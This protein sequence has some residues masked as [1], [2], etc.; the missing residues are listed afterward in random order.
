MENYTFMRMGNLYQATVDAMVAAC[1]R[2]GAEKA[3]T[4]INETMYEI[5][6][7]SSYG[8]IYNH[9]FSETKGKVAVTWDDVAFVKQIIAA[10]ESIKNAIEQLNQAIKMPEEEYAKK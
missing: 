7:G 4:A 5:L 8:D 3:E 10:E 9:V 2:F 6:K 1:K